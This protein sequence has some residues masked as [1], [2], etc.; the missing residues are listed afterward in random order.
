MKTSPGGFISSCVSFLVRVFRSFWK[1]SRNF[2]SQSSADESG[3]VPLPLSSDVWLVSLL[4]CG[5]SFAEIIINKL[6]LYC[7]CLAL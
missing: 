6:L 4:P 2:L 3:L 7:K 1:D 5:V